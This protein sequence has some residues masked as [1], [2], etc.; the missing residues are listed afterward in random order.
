MHSH[1]V[2]ACLK[3]FR[4]NQSGNLS[5][6]CNDREHTTLHLSRKVNKNQAVLTTPSICCTC[7]YHSASQ[8]RLQCWLEDSLGRWEFWLRSL[9]SVC[10]PSPCWLSSFSSENSY[11]ITCRGRE[12]KAL[13]SSFQEIAGK[14]ELNCLTIFGLGLL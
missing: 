6:S 2:S 10:F 3:I 7:D 14:S 5:P 4:I 12:Y 8:G 11:C 1:K 9:S 13:S